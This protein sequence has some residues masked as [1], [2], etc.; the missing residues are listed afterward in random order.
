MLKVPYF[1]IFLTLSTAAVVINSTTKI[2]IQI[3]NTINILNNSNTDKCSKLAVG[4]TKLFNSSLETKFQM[5][6][7]TNLTQPPINSTTWI[8][9]CN[10]GMNNLFL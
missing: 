2:D 7:L 1:I 5:W 8:H 9:D 4:T 3:T 10:A 6:D